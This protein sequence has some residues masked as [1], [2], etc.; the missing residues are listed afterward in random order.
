MTAAAPLTAEVGERSRVLLRDLAETYAARRPV[1]TVAVLG[2]APLEPSPER[3]EAV[4]AA[5]LVVRVNGFAV[6]EPG[7]AP[8][9]GRS[10]HVIV[11]NRALRA[12]PAFFEGYRNRLYLMV[13]PARPFF[14]R[15]EVPSWWPADLGQVHL[16]N[17]SVVLPL[18]DA[19]GLD[20]MRD[21]LWATTGT[22]AAWW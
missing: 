17:D 22:V 8:T 10:A 19:L 7:A 16:N 4:E 2:N 15:E 20:M 6:D 12:T 3:V 9:Y 5:D 11:F 18:S 13:E 14:E 21:G 1:R